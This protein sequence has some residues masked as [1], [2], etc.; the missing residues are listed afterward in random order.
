MSTVVPLNSVGV[1][2]W[3]SGYAFHSLAYTGFT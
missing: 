3:V 1:D 2:G